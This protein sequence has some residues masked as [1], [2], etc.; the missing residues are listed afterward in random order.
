M[1][2]EVL[3]RQTYDTKADIWSLGITV[4]AILTGGLH[5]FN[6]DNKTKIQQ[7]I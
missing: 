6:G 5:P 7:R 3:S 1:A 4:Y 2:P